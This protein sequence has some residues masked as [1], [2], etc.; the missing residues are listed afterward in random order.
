MNIYIIGMRAVGKSSVGQ[1]LAGQL[2][3]P[4]IDMDR[5]LAS[6][7]KQNIAD[8][9]R[10][11]GWPA[12][13]TREE[14]LLMRIAKLE[15]HVVATGGGVIGAKRSI[16]QMRDSGWVVWLKAGL[17]TLVKRLN[18]DSLNSGMRPPVG[19]TE[20]AAAELDSLLQ[21]RQEAYRKA[22]HIAV[23]T[24]RRTIEMIC[25]DIIA[26]SEPIIAAK[27]TKD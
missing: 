4:F 20:D 26:Q 6:E 18:E 1:F 19:H 12:F 21:A 14:A 5:E 3:R 23:D 17:S 11:N 2:G 7:F 25:R 13:R 22:M 8:F 10:A 27:Q 16:T 24:E 9:V 15:G